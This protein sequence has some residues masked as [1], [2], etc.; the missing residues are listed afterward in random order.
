MHAH[1]HAHVHP[2]H[3]PPTLEKKMQKIRERAG[4]FFF[5]GAHA[6]AQPGG[7]ADSPLQLRRSGDVEKV[8]ATFGAPRYC[9]EL[10]FAEKPEKARE[11]AMSF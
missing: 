7:I 11:R 6:S 8:T 2:Q 4:R 9:K 3:Q 10:N 5:S 1:A